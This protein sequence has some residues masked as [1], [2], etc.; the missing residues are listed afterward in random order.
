MQPNTNDD[1]DLIVE[2]LMSQ[3]YAPVA[4]FVNPGLYISKCLSMKV[5]LENGSCKFFHDLFNVKVKVKCIAL[6]LLTFISFLS[7]LRQKCRVS[8]EYMH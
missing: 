1:V 6:A 8:K 5:E 2:L 7:I 4:T 3:K